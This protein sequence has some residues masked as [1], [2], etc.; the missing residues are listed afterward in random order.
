VKV[1]R[2]SVGFGPIVA[3]RQSG[4][5]EYALSAIPLGGYVKMLGEDEDVTDPEDRARSFSAQSLGRRTA[6]VA[7]GPIM[8][9][10]FA[11]V[12][13]VVLAA[14][15]GVQVPSTEPVIGAVSADMPAAAAGLEVGD[16]VLAVDGTGVDSWTG[17]AELVRA[18]GG[19]RLTLSVERDGVARD[20]AVTPQLESTQSIFG[21]EGEAYL[22]GVG[23]RYDH[24]D[25][26][27]LEAV[28]AG[29]SQTAA[30]SWLVTKGFILMF[31]GR[32]PL[33]E[34]G[35]PIAIAQ[36]A[37]QQARAGADAFLTMLAFLSV[38]L[39]VLNLLPIPVLDGGHLALFG[40]EAVLRRPLRPRV[41][42]M[43]QQFGLLVLVSLMVLV[44]FNDVT[45]LVQG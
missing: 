23:A 8:N 7:A 4:E 27:L 18:S 26:G 31:V 32:V 5:T 22:I 2:F 44:L 43:A 21:E 25:L 15:Y 19:R 1:E 33:K 17:L 42:E 28:G 36:A 35:G 6:I 12:A 20:V 3:S 30:T 24:R 40:V 41:R 34:L 13:Y 38:N 45:R 29:A 9:L 16:R 37:G 11:L 39:G 10:A 14:V